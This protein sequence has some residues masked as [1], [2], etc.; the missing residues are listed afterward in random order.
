MNKTEELIL[1]EMEKSDQAL[2][3]AATE[4]PQVN[5]SFS[6]LR[7][8][9]IL[10]VI[11]GDEVAGEV[12]RHLNEE[13][14]HSIVQEL[15]NIEQVTPEE[16]EYVAREFYNIITAHT[17]VASGGLDYAK[18]LLVMSM[19]SESGKRMFDKIIS[20]ME[21]PAVFETLRKVNPQQLAKILQNEHPQTIAMVL[22]HLNAATAAEV[23]NYFS[24]TQCSNLMIRMAN[25]QPIPQNVI[26]R[27]SLVL[28]Q[29]VKSVDD[30][31]QQPV[32][33]VRAVA[34][35][36]NRLDRE[37]ARK[38]LEEIE[39]SDP[40]LALAIRNL[41]VTFDDLLLL[42]DFGIREI[43]KYVDKKALAL[44]LKGALPE[45]Q[46]RFFANMA[47]RAVDMMK[48]EMEFMGQV[49]MKDVSVAQREVVNI[50][51]ELDE[52]GIISLTGSSDAY[53]S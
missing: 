50:M 24:E 53:V 23:L 2:A 51:R 31:S 30:F 5:F 27:V 16:A 12:F 36:C 22:A 18:R 40:D 14:V 29:K 42:D 39:L 25:L 8:A 52:K 20:S 35:L 47:A 21:A 6:G 26:K 9:A 11:L 37:N 3:L 43:L 17:Y 19:G 41:M 48:E 46:T 49:K 28:S 33:G 10:L 1:S 34:E 4:T 13:D 45:I 15:A 32:G 7:K 44:A 38:T